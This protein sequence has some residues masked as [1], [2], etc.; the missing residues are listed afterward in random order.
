MRRE[1]PAPVRINNAAHCQ[2][3]LVAG[4]ERSHRPPQLAA[5]CAAALCQA[6]GG[7]H[8]SMHFVCV[9]RCALRCNDV[10][11]IT[12]APRQ[13]RAPADQ[14]GPASSAARWLCAA[15]VG[16]D[17]LFVARV[18]RPVCPEMSATVATC[19]RLFRARNELHS[20]QVV[21][22][23]HFVVMNHDKSNMDFQSDPPPCW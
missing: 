1:A 14:L 9:F 22:C 7:R 13:V 18:M 4:H 12:N 10:V 11:E 6:V 21:M 16:V 20:R 8:R 5:G 3:C 2:H 19:L 23:S 15:H 17:A